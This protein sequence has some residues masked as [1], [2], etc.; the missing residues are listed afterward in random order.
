MFSSFM[1]NFF[2][3]IELKPRKIGNHTNENMGEA[4]SN[5]GS[6]KTYYNAEIDSW[7]LRNPGKPVTI[8]DLGELIGNAFLKA[9]T[10][11]NITKSF[12]ACGIFPFDR[13]IFDDKDF[14]PSS[15]TD[16]PCPDCAPRE[17]RP[18]VRTPPA[19]EHIELN[20][21]GTSG[22][23]T[24]SFIQTTATVSQ[25]LDSET[26]DVIRLPLQP[27]ESGTFSNL[28]I[29][30]NTSKPLIEIHSNDSPSASVGSTSIIDKK[31]V[32]ITSPFQFRD[33]IKA[34]PR[35]STRQPRK[36]GR[37]LIATDSPK[38]QEIELTH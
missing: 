10:P 24:K 17:E 33:P 9:M 20:M 27:L 34:G 36:L 38:K 25:S 8:Y 26:L 11:V 29:L 13:N 2:S 35:K 15:V 22:L 12:K 19:Q 28:N 21:P 6:F 14:L 23:S 4:L 18:A 37:S 32:A 31:S 1:F 5:N 30:A 16:R 3:F 7:M